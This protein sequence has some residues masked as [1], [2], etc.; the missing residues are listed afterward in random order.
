MAAATQEEMIVKMH[1]PAGGVKRARWSHLDKTHRTV[2]PVASA[3]I[4]DEY[5]LLKSADRHDWLFQTTEQTDAEV[6]ALYME[7][8]YTAGTG[9]FYYADCELWQ[10]VEIDD[11]AGALAAGP[12]AVAFAVANNFPWTRCGEG[13]CSTHS[14]PLL[15]SQPPQINAFLPAL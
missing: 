3:P 6:D 9:V 4:T 15:G 7:T 11:R 10:T 12:E 1:A 5:E 13:N 14:A 8:V 2:R